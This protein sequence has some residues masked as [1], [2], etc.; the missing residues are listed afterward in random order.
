MDFY[1][2]RAETKILALTTATEL[3]KKTLALNILL[4]KQK[5]SVALLIPDEWKD[6]S[7]ALFSSVRSEDASRTDAQIVVIH[8]KKNPPAIKGI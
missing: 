4:K 6:R 3:K 7:T 8:T 1:G 2:A 5:K